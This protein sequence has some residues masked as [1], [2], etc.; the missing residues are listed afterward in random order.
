MLKG[1]EDT[2][3]KGKEDTETVGH[4]YCNNLVHLHLLALSK[5]LSPS[6]MATT[7]YLLSSRKHSRNNTAG[8]H[9]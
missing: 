9:K 7:C 8:K 5:A 3:L 6:L 2:M 4:T 1:K